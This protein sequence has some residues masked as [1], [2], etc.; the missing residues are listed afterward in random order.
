M[1]KRIA[2]AVM[3]IG[4][5]FALLSTGC[6]RYASKKTLGELEEA[7]I[8]AEA[9]EAKARDLEAELKRLEEDIATKKA[10][11]DELKTELEKCKSIKPKRK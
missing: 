1:L 4:F 2:S 3:L 6:H 10:K 5:S 11:V 9:A 8:A 7:R